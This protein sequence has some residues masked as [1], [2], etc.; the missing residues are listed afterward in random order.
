MRPQANRVAL[1]D[2]SVLCVPSLL[3]AP[4]MGAGR[5][6]RESGGW[7][8]AM[9]ALH[10]QLLAQQ[11]GPPGSATAAPDMRAAYHCTMTLAYPN[12]KK[13]FCMRLDRTLICSA[14]ACPRNLRVLVTT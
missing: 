14:C 13:V 8:G 3:N 6:V 9:E 11:T 4:G 12:G 7:E 1:A 5:L 10:E 2:C